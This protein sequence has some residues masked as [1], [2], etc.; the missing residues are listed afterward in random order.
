[1]LDILGKDQ[2]WEHQVLLFPHCV[3]VVSTVASYEGHGF[4]S[5]VS[6]RSEWRNSKTGPCRLIR[7][8]SVQGL[9][10]WELEISSSRPTPHRRATKWVR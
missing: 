4:D 7:D 5:E 1:M 10:P 8:G 2:A 6:V 9:T 3:G